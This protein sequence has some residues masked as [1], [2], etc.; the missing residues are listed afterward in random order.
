MTDRGNENEIVRERERERR[1]WAR[2]MGRIRRERRKKALSTH[3][4]E[5]RVLRRSS[6]I[7]SEH[8]RDGQSELELHRWDFPEKKDEGRKR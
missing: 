1:D 7:E 2:R 6:K 4:L 3:A 8:R 5:Q